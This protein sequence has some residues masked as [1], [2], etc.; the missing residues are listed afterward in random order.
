[1]LRILNTEAVDEYRLEIKFSNGTTLILN[2]E[3]KVKT[4]RFRQLKDKELFRRVS[5]DGHSIKWNE[6]IEI[7][8]TEAFE[9]AQS[10]ITAK[11]IDC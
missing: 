10:N 5:T 6:L 2:L 11:F 1:M 3:D 7:S 9:I 4:I 8:A